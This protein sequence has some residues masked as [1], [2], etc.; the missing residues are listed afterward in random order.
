MK[1]LWVGLLLMSSIHCFGQAPPAA[2]SIAV[3][4]KPGDVPSKLAPRYS[5]KGRQ[6]KLTPVKSDDPKGSMVEGLEPLETRLRLGTTPGEGQLITLTRSAV[7]R[8]YDRL[9]VDL[10]HDGKLTE[11]A[12]L[13]EPKVVRGSTW[14]SFEATIE[15]NQAAEGD[16]PDLLAYP[17]SLWVV[18]EDPKQAP[19]LIRI[20]RRGFL[21]GEVKYKDQTLQLVVSDSDN[22]GVI[23][24]GDWWELRSTPPSKTAGSRTIGDFQWGG[25]Q[26]WQLELA[27]GNWRKATLQPHDPQ[28]TEEEDAEI[29]DHLR[30]DRLAAR[31]KKAVAFRKDVDAALTEAAAAKTT[32]FIKFETEW[33]GPCKTMAELVFTAQDVAD[34]AQGK[35]CIVVDGDERKELA[36]KFAV[37]GYPTG[38]LLDGEGKE[39]ARYVGYQSVKQ[40]TAFLGQAEKK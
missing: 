29:R 15:V 39:V 30:E 16:A 9:F 5:P 25:G 7:D 26:A 18:A 3:E 12:L 28:M 33:C 4:L 21:L 34:A 24:Q 37:K 32:H 19:D 40:T 1:S 31:A 20:S 23:Q 6:F 2:S 36:E 11:P 38:I 27:R 10:N 35:I 17:I 13:C 22:D 8:P 14:S